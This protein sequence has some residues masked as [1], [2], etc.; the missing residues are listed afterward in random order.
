MDFDLLSIAPGAPGWIELRV[1]GDDQPRLLVKCE[2]RDGRGVITRVVVAGTLD[3]AVLRSIP[4]GRI[5]AAINHPKFGFPNM[6]GPSPEVVEKFAGREVFPAEIGAMDRALDDYLAK[7]EKV[8]RRGGGSSSRRKPRE[9]LSRPDGTNPD[10]FSRRVAEAYSDVVLTTPAPAVVLA[11]EAGVPVGTV[12]RWIRE[13]RQ[14][15]HLPQ[16]RKGRAG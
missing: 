11:E 15:G 8:V 1:K 6:Q 7:S 16:A 13:A 2:E 12:H 14:R 5:E 10:E 9:P 3:S 4:F